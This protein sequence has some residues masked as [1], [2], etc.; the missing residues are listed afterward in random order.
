MCHCITLCWTLDD[1]EHYSVNEP[2]TF[3]RIRVEADVLMICECLALRLILSCFCASR[4]KRYIA[5]A[6]AFV[7][8]V[9]QLEAIFRREKGTLETEDLERNEEMD[10]LRPVVE[11]LNELQ[12]VF[13][14]SGIPNYDKVY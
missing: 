4:S 9:R 5:L 8:Q 1:P 2:K 10:R 7:Q 11:R 3:K 14:S 12:T 13:D 6:E